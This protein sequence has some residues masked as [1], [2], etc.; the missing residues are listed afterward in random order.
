MD[1]KKYYHLE[2]LD[3]ANC[4]AELERAIGGLEQ[5]SS[6][7]I[8]FMA[9]RLV[10]EAPEEQY[11]AVLER[12]R[13]TIAE[14]EPGVELTE[15]TGDGKRRAKQH[16][17]DHDHCDCQECYECSACEGGGSSPA[18]S[19][20]RDRAYLREQIIRIVGC[21]VILVAAMFMRDEMSFLS[22]LLMYLIAYLFIGYDILW[23]ALR[24]IF[25][26][27]VFDENFLMSIA[28][29]GA[30]V[31]GEYPEGVAVM[32]FYQ[33]GE[34]FQHYAVSRS[35]RSIAGLMDIRPDYANVLVDGEIVTGAPEDVEIGDVMVVKAGEKIPLD[36]VVIEGNSTVD[37]SALTG[38][39][40]PREVKEQDEVLSGCINLT[41]LLHIRVTREFG[42]STVSKILDLVENAGS[43]KASAENFITKFARYYTPIVVGLAVLLAVIP[44]LAGLG[45]WGEWVYR[46]LSF[47]VVSCP[48]ALVISIPLGFFG[49]IGGASRRGVLIKGGNY[50]EALARTEVVVFD[51]TGT[52]TEGKFA[53]SAVYPAGGG[54]LDPAQNDPAAASLLERA[55]CAE[56][57]SNH[58]IS[59][60]IRAAYGKQ[61][62]ETRVTD[63][64]EAGGHGVSAQVDG[65]L[66]LA[67]NR[68]LMAEH[69]IDAPEIPEAGTVVYLAEEGRYLGAI[70]IAD[71]V[72]PDAKRAIA[73]L[74]AA[75]VKKTV[76]LTGDADAVAQAVA[77]ELG[78]DEAHAELLPGDKVD[79]VER[80]L[81]GKSA[82]GKLAFVGDGIN[83]APVLARADIGIAMGALG[84]DA[85]IEAADVVLMTDEPSRIATAMRISRRTLRIVKQNIVFALLVKVAVLVLV[86]FGLS[87]MWEAVFA[88]V[89]V[90]VIAILNSMRALRVKK[91]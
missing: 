17:H 61:P 35:R 21:A 77:R 75:G 78:L 9:K 83:D 2:G 71:R 23:K 14:L 30:F 24:G 46:A 88:D 12:T 47:L 57:Y 45:T 41:G 49:G 20:E 85:A 29:A 33:I 1:M 44:P 74:K 4:A 8:N 37:T 64:T 38:E 58:P 16:T 55:A 15:E 68:R 70:V 26:G 89:G 69:K 76:M 11:E 13:A 10:L 28:T 6:A 5:V 51:K 79:Q 25:R 27:K 90:S 59:Q 39:S 36:G 91:L 48:C 82:K 3:C 63:V 54:R 73:D 34:L 18:D 7:S 80:L 22:E 52:L 81:D 53:V 40:L 50:L 56:V 86:A 72:K 31:I 43:K 87:T 67:G 66:V 84:S 42:E 60:S 62:D 32:L 65:K 19:G